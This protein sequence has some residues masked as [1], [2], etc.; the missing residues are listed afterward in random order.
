[1]IT[2]KDFKNEFLNR[3]NN[4]QSFTLLMFIK[5]TWSR[6]FRNNNIMIDSSIKEFEKHNLIDFSEDKMAIRISQ[7]GINVIEKYKKYSKYKNIIVIENIFKDN[8]Y[9]FVSIILVILQIY[10]SYENGKQKNQIQILKKEYQVIN[11]KYNDV[12]DSLRNK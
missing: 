5:N 7:K 2:E 11:Q 6:P 4:L 12:L 3:L 8:I 1:M 10:T 9:K